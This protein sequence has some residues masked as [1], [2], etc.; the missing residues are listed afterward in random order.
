ML[1]T[2]YVEA[3]ARAERQAALVGVD[4]WYTSDDDVFIRIAEHRPPQ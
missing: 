4:A 2:A 3:R 1:Y